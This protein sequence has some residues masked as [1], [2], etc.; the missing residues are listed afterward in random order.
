MLATRSEPPGSGLLPVRFGS[1]GSRGCVAGRS[2]AFLVCTVIAARR[3]GTGEG[4]STQGDR[5]SRG[6][7]CQRAREIR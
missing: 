1:G 4:T 7:G 3:C 6:T 2:N 5:S